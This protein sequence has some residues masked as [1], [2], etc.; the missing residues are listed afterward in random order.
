MQ[1]YNFLLVKSFYS[2][3]KTSRDYLLQTVLPVYNAPVNNFIT[4]EER[5]F[6]FHFKVTLLSRTTN[7]IKQVN[8][9]QCTVTLI[10]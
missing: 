10:I 2:Q 4:L 3:I 1:Y 9:I 6:M 7:V 5:G 8:F